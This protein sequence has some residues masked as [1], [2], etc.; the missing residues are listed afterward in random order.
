MKKRV[1]LFLIAALLTALLIPVGV[2]AD[3]VTLISDQAGLAAM[4]ETGSY[5]LAADVTISGEWNNDVLFTGTF[6]GDGHTVT[7]ADGAVINGGLFKQFREGA[8]VKNLNIVSGN[9]TWKTGGPLEGIGTSCMGGLVASIEAGNGQYNNISVITSV[10]NIVTIQ[11]VHVTADFSTIQTSTTNLAIGGIVGDL[12][13][14]TRIENCSFSGRISDI[15]RSGIDMNAYTSG[16]GG[17]VGVAVRNCGPIAIT[18]CVNNAV[19]SG[20]GQIGG[21]LGYSR[22]WGGGET[23]PASLI[24]Q[25]CV[26]NAT[27]TCLQ[28]ELGTAANL[29]RATVGGIAGY[30]YVKDGAVA[31]LLNNINYGDAVAMGSE[32][33]SISAGI[34]GVI[35]QKDTVTFAGNINFGVA[36]AN[37][38]CTGL[39]SGI[40]NYEN[41]YA[42]GA[43]T[44]GRYISFESAGGVSA[45]CDALNAIYPGVY[46]YEDDKIVLA[47]GSSGSGSGTLDVPQ[48]LTMDVTVPEPTGTAIA[49][50]SE[51]EA[52]KADGIYYLTEDIVIKGSFKSLSGFSGVLHG[53]GHTVVLDGVE[54]RGG[55]FR[56][57]AGGKIY[58]LSFTEAPGSA[59]KNSYRGQ[60]SANEMDLCF[61]TVAGY[62][63]GTMVNVVTDCAIGSVL[64][65]TSN[66]YVGGL[67]G[68]VTDGETI[69][70]HC[71]NTGHVQGAN[72]GGIAGFVNCESGKVEIS[73]CVN[74]GEVDSTSGSAGGIFSIHS[75]TDTQVNMSLL[76]LENV[77]YGAVSAS[78]SRYCGGIAGS[79]QSFWGGKA[80]FLRNVNCGT[81]TGNAATESS[82]ALGCPGGLIGYVGY[83]GIM[84]SGNINLGAVEGNNLPNRLISVCESSNLVAENNFAAE[85]AIPATVGQIAG[86]VIDAETVATLNAAY[87]NAFA[88]QEGQIVL[89][90]AADEGLTATA[91]E[92]TYSVELNEEQTTPDTAENTTEPGTSAP[93]TPADTSGTESETPDVGGTPEKGCKSAVGIGGALA[94]VLMLGMAVATRRK[95]D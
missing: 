55:F 50:Q 37:M 93:E 84:I 5:K 76:V 43:G 60:L 71:N 80:A 44:D 65:G 42:N 91:P 29:K 51:L 3:D 28:T 10:A 12:G 31:Q 87:E 78:A 67:I 38:M 56:S 68:I 94:L 59:G 30:V 53:N 58:D 48:T 23:A 52:M 2:S 13:L 26:N 88:A 75:L 70:Y 39:S 46:A 35:R 77:N 62:G 22:G 47:N 20:F 34:C 73:R 11:N 83:E 79:L 81:V 82:T 4:T 63:Y 41:N 33:F 25:R 14:I 66:A 8:T 32:D 85:G 61:G 64:K 9:V 40:V 36:K 74:W 17:I 19:I 24:I 90:W 15:N 6:D 18:G 16:C 86:A 95:E 92:V 49:S 27:V 89:K 72:A 1:S 21:I 54:L 45:A 7:F 57:I 69:L